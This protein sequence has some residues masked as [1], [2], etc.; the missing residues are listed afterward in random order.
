[1]IGGKSGYTQISQNTLVTAARRGDRELIAVVMKSQNYEVYKD[2]I[3]LF[4]Y[5]FNQFTETKIL[6]CAM[7]NPSRGDGENKIVQNT[8]GQNKD[9]S[10]TSWFKLEYASA[11]CW[12]SDVSQLRFGLLVLRRSCRQ[13]PA[14]LGQ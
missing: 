7:V 3:A 4:D 13:R 6:P 2:T 14:F 8:L 11:N 9:F 10:I 1:V 5:G 12:Q